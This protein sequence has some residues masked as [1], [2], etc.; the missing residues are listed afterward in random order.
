[1]TKHFGALRDNWPARLTIAST[2]KRF[3]QGGLDDLRDWCR[4]AKRPVLI[5]ID[6]LKKVRPPKGR[7]QSDYDADYEGCEGL[8]KLAHEFAGLA[9][10]I[11]HHTRKMDADDVFDTV[12][13]T[14][15]LIGGV[16]TIGSFQ[17][18]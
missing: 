14:L 3:D 13:G 4:G 8:V 17:D 5:M 6:T 12:S 16:D 1:M 10:M 9:I 15:G 18:C 7:N 2:W 11:A